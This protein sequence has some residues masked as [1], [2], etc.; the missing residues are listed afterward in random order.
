MIQQASAL[1]N[2]AS[3]WRVNDEAT[4]KLMQEFYGQLKFG[5]VTISQALRKAQISLN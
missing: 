4:Q 3:L 1:A 5:N 2:L